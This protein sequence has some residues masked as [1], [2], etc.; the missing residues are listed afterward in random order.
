MYCC[1]SPAVAKKALAEGSN[2]IYRTCK[3]C[4]LCSLT[5]STIIIEQLITCLMYPNVAPPAACTHKIPTTS[6]CEQQ[7]QACKLKESQ[8][9]TMMNAIIVLKL[10]SMAGLVSWHSIRPSRQLFVTNL[11]VAC[12]RAGQSRTVTAKSAPYA[13]PGGCPVFDPKRG[14]QRMSIL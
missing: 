12:G 14:F 11:A 5:P 2:C 6:P 13:R 7:S 1:L 8:S 9:K 4:L 10:A 3:R